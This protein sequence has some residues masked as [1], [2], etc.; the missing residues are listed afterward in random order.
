MATY[1]EIFDLKNN[2]DLQHRIQVAV[3][4]KAQTLLDKTTPTTNEVVWSGNALSGPEGMGQKILFYV[5]AKNSASS[6]AA[7]TAASDATI[8]SN[9]DAAV[10]ALIAGGVTS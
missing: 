8:Q 3:T 2:N 4:K 7:I 10:D 6:V 9:V 1:N 5:L